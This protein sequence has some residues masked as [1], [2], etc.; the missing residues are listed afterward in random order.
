[1]LGLLLGL[2]VVGPG[3]AETPRLQVTAEPKDVVVLYREAAEAAGY[4]GAALLPACREWSSHFFMC[5]MVE[6]EGMRRMVHLGDLGEWGMSLEEAEATASVRALG[7]FVMESGREVHPEGMS[8]SYWVFDRGDG[9]ASSALLLPRELEKHLGGTPNIAVP[10]RD[11]VIAWVPG[12]PDFDRMIAI[13]VRRLY[14]ES[15][16]P[17]SPVV[18]RWNGKGWARWGE[19]YATP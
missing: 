18:M 11:L 8:A 1:M 16:Q 9:L 4:E 13:G 6:E 19:A 15:D 12:D 10:G 5:F 17:V 3:L 7:S 2:L 14:E